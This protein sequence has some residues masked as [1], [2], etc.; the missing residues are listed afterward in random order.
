MKKIFSF[1]GLPGSGKGTQAEMFARERNLELLGIGDLIREEIEKNPQSKIVHEIEARYDKG[2]P[3]P[4]KIVFELIEN[5][6]KK[7]DCGVVFDNFPFSLPQINFLNEFK[8]NGWDLPKIIYIKITPECSLQRIAARKTCPKCNK[9][10]KGAETECSKCGE[11]LI[12]REDDNKDVVKKRIDYYV[13]RIKEVIEY[14]EKLSRVYEVDGEPSIPE[15]KKQ[16]DKI[17]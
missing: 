11:K 12:I 10:Y 8:K 14:F 2:V 16:I 4:D 6:L 5:K 3:Q 13:P 15:V 7:L 9:I 17:Q 1:I